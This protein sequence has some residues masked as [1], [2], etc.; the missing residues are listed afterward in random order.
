VS[1]QARCPAAELFAGP[2]TS[3]PSVLCRALVR[4][5]ARTDQILHGRNASPLAT[6]QRDPTTVL[7]FCCGEGLPRATDDV[8]RPHGHYTFCPIWELEKKRIAEAKEMMREP[9]Q[10]GMSAAAEAVLTGA[11]RDIEKGDALE[12]W[13]AEEPRDRT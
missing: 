7:G 3:G 8:S 5:E 1:L 10:K 4:D 6:L 12:E 2:P 13:M 11:V 9:A